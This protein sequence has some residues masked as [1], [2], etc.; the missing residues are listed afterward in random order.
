MSSWE[1]RPPPRG[2]A[3]DPADEEEAQAV[4]TM[5][6]NVQRLSRTTDLMQPAC[7][8]LE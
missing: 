6:A 7:N 2:C 4:R 5:T 8:D 1:R 3:H